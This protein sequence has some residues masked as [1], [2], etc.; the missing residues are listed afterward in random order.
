MAANLRELALKVIEAVEKLTGEKLPRDILE[1]D[2]YERDI[3]IRFRRPRHFD[4]GEYVYHDIVIFRDGD[5]DD[6]TAVEVLD[7]DFVLREA[8]RPNPRPFEGL[9]RI[10]PPED[11]DRW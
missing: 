3:F 6:I 4:S 1:I 5:E 10:W 7:Y 8:Q 9:V 2:M 11:E